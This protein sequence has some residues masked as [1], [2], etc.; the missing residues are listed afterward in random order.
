[1]KK[2]LCVSVLAAMS[3][4]AAESPAKPFNE[5]G[6]GTVSGRIQSLT[7]YRDYDDVGDGFNSTVG[8]LLNYTSPELAGFDFGLGYNYA[9]EIYDYNK[10][11][12]LA[13][14]EIHVLNEAWLRYL[15]TPETSLVAGRKIINGEVFR[16]DD[17][18]QKARSVEAVQLE[19]K[20]IEGLSV[21]L[22]HA[23]RMSNWLQTGDRADFNDFGD[24]FGAQDDT[25]GVTW[26][27]AVF[28]RVEGLEIALFN[29][30]AYDVANLIGTRAKLSVTETTSLLGYYR[31]ESDVGDS[32]GSD[33][34][35]VGVA[36]EQKAGPVTL[37]PGYFGVRG[38][39]LRFQETTTGINH[40]LGSLMMIYSG[41]FAGDSDT[42]YFKATT[43]IRTTSLYA[44]YNY[45]WNSSLPYD[46][47]ELN[48]VIKQPIT[49]QVTVAL[50]SG[51]GYRSGPADT[52]ASDTRLFVT[53][54]F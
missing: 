54:G 51:L 46:G 53:Y 14:D 36:V 49:D 34:D 11:S 30:Y 4:A 37:E 50:K 32:T 20:E 44:L 48:L 31:H 52:F 13:N 10:S 35:A 25:D 43:K 27:E 40:P 12:M 6:Y 45:T 5:L 26:G 15:F 28:S 23:I 17:Y 16:A 8:V 9:G 21:T 24:V 22:G 29:A 39:N 38:D 7:M 3:V 42:L 18:R 41:Q 33:S 1:M 19:M 2:M 47:Q